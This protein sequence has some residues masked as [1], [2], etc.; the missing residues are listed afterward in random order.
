MKKIYI[1]LSVAL[2]AA[3]CAKETV[4]S[5]IPEEN[6]V[7]YTFSAGPDGSKTTFNG[8]DF[9]WT[10][11]DRISVF[12]ADLK[13]RRFETSDSGVRATFVGRAKESTSFYAFYP[14]DPAL[15]MVDAGIVD[16]V[17][18][19]SQKVSLG[20]IGDGVNLSMGKLS[21]SDPAGLSD[22]SFLMKNVGGYVKIILGESA[23]PISQMT[24][25]SGGGEAISGGVK[26]D[27]TGESPVA[28]SLGGMPLIGLFS[29]DTTFRAGTYYAVA[30]PAK[31]SKGLK[32]SLIRADDYTAEVPFDDC[33]AIVRNSA[34]SST[35]TLADPDKLDWKSPKMD[36]LHVAFVDYATDNLKY[37]QPFDE[38]LPALSSPSSALS[39][40]PY[41]LKDTGEE[42]YIS[43]TSL[44]VNSAY[45]L[46]L[47]NGG[48][49]TLP[50]MVGKRLIEVNL[51]YGSGSVTVPNRICI[52]SDEDGAEAVPG[53][54]MKTLGP[55][56]QG[57]VYSWNLTE[58]IANTK[59]RLVSLDK[60][61]RI[62]SMNLVYI[63]RNVAS[64]ASASITDAKLDD[65][66]ITVSGKLKAVHPEEGIITWGVEYRD[67]IDTEWTAGPTGAGTEFSATITGID[68]SRTWYVRVFGRA[69]AGENVYSEERRLRIATPVTYTLDKLASNE[70]DGTSGG[71]YWQYL[72]N[73]T[74][75]VFPNDKTS[76]TNR[77]GKE[78]FYA[79]YASPTDTEP[80][81]SGIGF[82]SNGTGGY[83]ISASKL[84]H[85]GGYFIFPGK[86]GY[87]ISKISIS[88]SASSGGESKKLYVCQADA[89]SSSDKR[90][91]ESNPYSGT[92]TTQVL[93]VNCV[94]PAGEAVKVF[95]PS[96]FN[97]FKLEV[98]YT[99]L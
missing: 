17:I 97:V 67:E 44:T 60:N 70:Y 94:A 47:D 80:L 83:F 45:G 39:A 4:L 14:Y 12:D 30:T 98:A 59:Y 49:V 16:A 11:G 35:L 72:G 31:L 66:E 6:L 29:V 85:Y 34:K 22:K 19:S 93:E 51:E 73:R 10:P 88:V 69:D 13:N 3:A 26:V 62:R 78:D 9:I 18:P 8:S 65:G 87:Y 89:K 1:L 20:T 52:T 57:T 75:Y 46:R 81:L 64:V 53:G 48:Y 77:K 99:P 21:S 2:I 86:A 43:T 5:E 79:Y 15:R 68:N 32:L 23:T 41:H 63:G 76:G 61:M 55:N 38:D 96:A 27:Y 42:F 24:I 74:G 36:T 84:M 91:G 54:E 7:E 95:S 25:Q 90:I 82:Y 50:A 56:A 40:D 92:N 33:G 28:S 58:A 37:L 71:G